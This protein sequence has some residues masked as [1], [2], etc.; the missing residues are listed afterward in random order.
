M[1][2]DVGI[3]ELGLN[4]PSF[5]VPAPAE[6]LPIGNVIGFCTELQEMCE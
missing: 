2:G 6:P 3:S 5:G 1:A 4:I